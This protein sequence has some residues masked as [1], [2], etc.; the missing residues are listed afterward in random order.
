MEI[1]TDSEAALSR[2]QEALKPK[3]ARLQRGKNAG[4]QIVQ[5]KAIG[6]NGHDGIYREAGQ[7][8]APKLPLLKWFSHSIG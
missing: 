4:D 7:S 3:V 2:F 1:K 8:G 5:F 6:A